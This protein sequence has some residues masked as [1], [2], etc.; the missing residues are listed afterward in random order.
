MNKPSTRLDA[1]LQK[2]L[3]RQ[4]KSLEDFS[5][6]SAQNKSELLVNIIRSTTSRYKR[7]R[8]TKK[9]F[10]NLFSELKK[11]YDLDIMYDKNYI[12]AKSAFEEYVNSRE[13]EMSGLKRPSESRN[14]QQNKLEI[15]VNLSECFESEYDWKRMET[16]IT[17]LESDLIPTLLSMMKKPLSCLQFARMI[18]DFERIFSVKDDE[19]WENFIQCIKPYVKAKSKL[20]WKHMTILFN[21]LIAGDE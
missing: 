15:K 14:E 17:K 4:R 19:E 2:G 20:F 1:W 10:Q 11:E 9:S 13:E 8:L 7:K 5:S 16:E 6:A 3:L 18:A 12:Q 21:K